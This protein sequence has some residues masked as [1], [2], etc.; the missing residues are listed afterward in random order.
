MTCALR[1]AAATLLAGS[2]LALS[3]CNTIQG[4]GRDVTRTGEVLEDLTTD[5]SDVIET[6]PEVQPA[7]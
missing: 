2:F 4:I 1:I 6:A 3:A 7:P 5:A